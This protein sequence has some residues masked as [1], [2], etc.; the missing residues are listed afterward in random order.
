MAQTTNV[1]TV[2]INITAYNNYVDNFY[3]E[4]DLAKDIVSN[5]SKLYINQIFNEKPTITLTPINENMS[6]GSHPTTNVPVLTAATGSTASFHYNEMKSLLRGFNASTFY[7]DW[8]P[9]SSSDISQKVQNLL[10]LSF[11]NNLIGDK[12]NINS[13][14][15]GRFEF[16]LD[17][18][19]YSVYSYTDT[20]FSGFTYEINNQYVNEVSNFGLI[21]SGST[22][23]ASNFRGLFFGELGL[24]FFYTS[25][26]TIAMPNSIKLINAVYQESLNS[27][28]FFC[29]VTNEKYNASTNP[30]WVTYSSTLGVNVVRSEVRDSGHT[31]TAITGIGLYNDQGQ[32]L[33][34]AKLSQ[35]VL[36]LVDTEL[37]ARVVIQ[38]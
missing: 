5:P 1:T 12:L 8:Y 36:K 25:S 6:T 20:V 31:Y 37:H 9:V 28:T 10:V 23:T 29:R 33:A 17:N 22:A 14:N 35:P 11:A 34:I 2:P 15:D 26:G 3:T 32:L 13:T 30:T 27:K 18:N 38:Y 21:Y 24:L 19:T 7:N 16:A 4:F